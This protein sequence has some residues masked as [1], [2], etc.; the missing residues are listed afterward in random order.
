MATDGA[1]GININDK[2]PICG[3]NPNE[4]GCFVNRDIMICPN[5]GGCKNND[6]GDKNRRTGCLGYL[7]GN[8]G[9]GGFLGSN[10]LTHSYSA[11]QLEPR[12]SFTGG[13]IWKGFKDKIKKS[14]KEIV[15]K[16]EG[17]DRALQQKMFR[18]ELKEIADLAS[19]KTEEN[20]VM[21]QYG[22]HPLYIGGGS[23][24]AHHLI[25][26]E[27]M[28]TEDWRGFCKMTGYNINCWKNG[29]FLPSE[30]PLACAAKVPLHK[31]GHSQGYGG[32]GTSYVDQVKKIL[33]RISKDAN[34]NE[35]CK[36]PESLKGLIDQL[37]TASKEIYIN[38]EN[39]IWTI[40]WDGFDYQPGNPIGCANQTSIQDKQGTRRVKNEDGPTK[41]KK[42]EYSEAM[43][44]MQGS[45]EMAKSKRES[46]AKRISTIEDIEKEQE[47]MNKYF[48]KLKKNKNIVCPYGRV[49][50]E[51]QKISKPY[52]LKLGK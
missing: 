42:F 51:I 28:N 38:I 36:K 48:D 45:L 43:E 21:Y 6:E 17:S 46:I 27:A 9:I 20:G 3:K 8:V 35:L 41:T 25:C 49:H 23:I 16:L 11:L 44:K 13:K 26:S 34:T 40:T 22:P 30:L 33:E 7:C 12:D 32:V 14:N 50:N 19:G 37:N 1:S 24:E 29:V 52:N 15:A 5:G 18:A 47:S 10:I 31:G 4:E 2:C 39:F